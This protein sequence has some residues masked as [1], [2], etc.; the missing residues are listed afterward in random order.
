MNLGLACRAPTL[1]PPRPH[2]GLR[3]RRLISGA[4]R[5]GRYSRRCRTRMGCRLRSSPYQPLTFEKPQGL[6]GP[7]FQCLVWPPRITGHMVRG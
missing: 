3:Q 6:C 1:R 2:W 4:I 7:S 5:S